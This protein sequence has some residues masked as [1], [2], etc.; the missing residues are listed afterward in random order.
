MAFM[1]TNLGGSVTIGSY[2]PTTA[3]HL[4][5]GKEAALRAAAE[6]LCEKADGLFYIPGIRDLPAAPD[7]YFARTQAI[8]E[9]RAKVEAHLEQGA[10]LT[11]KLK[12][13]GLNPKGCM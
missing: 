13:M 12:S 11:R 9:F 10:D 3:S 8:S 4:G 2:T 6:A 7:G 1:F 5:K